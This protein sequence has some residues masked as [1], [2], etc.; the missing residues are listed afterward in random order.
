[1]IVRVPD[2]KE[3]YSHQVPPFWAGTK[4]TAVLFIQH[5]VQQ[6]QQHVATNL[7]RIDLVSGPDF[8]GHGPLFA[9]LWRAEAERV[10]VYRGPEVN[11]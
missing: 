11:L 1:M 7:N 8:M 2:T 9:L 6:W 3:L 10:L 5:V 4:N